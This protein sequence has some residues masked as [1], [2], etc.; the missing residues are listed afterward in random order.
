MGDLGKLKARKISRENKGTE[1]LLAKERQKLFIGKI[2][3]I[4]GII[5]AHLISRESK[6]T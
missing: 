4:L 6:A 2:I 1:D 3:G 5:K